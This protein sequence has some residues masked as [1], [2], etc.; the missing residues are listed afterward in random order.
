MSAASHHDARIDEL[1]ATALRGE[2]VAWP[3]D[4]LGEESGAAVVQ[5]ALYHGIAGLL[6]EIGSQLRGWPD[7]VMGQIKEQALGQTMWELRHRR[8]LTSLFAALAEQNITVALL[9]GTAIAYDLYTLPAS[10]ARG[11][12]DLLASPDDVPAVRHILSN[13]GFV[14]DPHAESQQDELLLQEIWHLDCA[15]GSGHDIDLHWQAMNAPALAGILTTEDCFANLTRLPRLSPEACAVDRGTLLLHTILHRAGHITSPYFL[16]N[17]AHYGGDRLIWAQDIH[18][19]ATS[20]QET[21]WNEL[22][23]RASTGGMAEVCL[24]GLQ[25]AHARLGTDLPATVIEALEN[26]PQ[27]GRATHYLLHSGQSARAWQ[28]LLAQPGWRR[29]VG[30]LTARVLP[31]PAFVRAKYPSMAGRPLPL[32]YLRRAFDLLRERPQRTE[33]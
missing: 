6:I 12:T 10:R 23:K 20:L 27:N 32:L 28:D 25:F 8:V 30:Y 2:V 26:A 24:D 14:R 29:K 4:W 1:L 9:K 11:D 13:L 3:C 18:R 16:G 17:V 33:H 15:D 5:R 19:L 7:F 22:I 31:A 21:E